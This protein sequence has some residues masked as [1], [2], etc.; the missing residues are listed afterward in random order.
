MVYPLPGQGNERIQLFLISAKAQDVE[1]L[2]LTW[3]DL[4]TL[5]DRFSHSIGLPVG[6]NTKRGVAVKRF[7]SP[8][9]PTACLKMCA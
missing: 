5:L 1:P 4:Q 3:D 9:D 7:S 8:T 6:D 2:N